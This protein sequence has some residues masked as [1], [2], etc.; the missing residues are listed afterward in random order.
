MEFPFKVAQISHNVSESSMPYRLNDALN[1]H[2][3]GTDS[4]LLLRRAGNGIGKEIRRSCYRR[5]QDS[6]KRWVAR[7]MCRLTV[8]YDRNTPFYS[9]LGMGFSVDQMEE[10]DIVNLHWI[11]GRTLD[12]SRLHL[13]GRPLVYTLHDTMPVTGGCHG[14]M[15]CLLYR[16][17]CRG[18]CPRLGHILGCGSWPGW[19]F[20]KKKEYFA[21]IPDLTIVT[22]SK[23]LLD[24]ARESRMFEGRRLVH[25]FNPVDTSVFIPPV[26]K[27]EAK[28][29]L[30]VPENSFVIAFGAVNLQD[31]FKGGEY[32]M[33]ILRELYRQGARHIH[34]LIFGNDDSSTEWPYPCTRMGF[35]ADMG[36]LAQVYQG[37]DMFLNPTKQDSLFYVSL[38]AMSCGV[39]SVS[40]RTGGVPEVC[41]DGKTGLIADQF[42]IDRMA[43]HCLLLYNDNQLLKRLGHAGREYAEREFSYPVIASRYASLY[44]EILA[45]GCSGN[46]R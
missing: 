25:I 6:A 28:K 27:A 36:K 17:S 38:E 16:N 31:P 15:G 20:R 5:M 43:A 42:D 35:L 1:R 19:L 2:A 13:I 21:R 46:I 26:N 32:V 14:E 45:T 3:E 23:W 29:R 33:P 12:F 11:A 9:V 8:P 4:H 40:F 34:L 41:L 22:P 39:P 30:D 18:D 44:R 37:A 24:M 10:A 7:G